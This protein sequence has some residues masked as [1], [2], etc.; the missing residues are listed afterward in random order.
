MSR[1][2]RG[3]RVLA[4]LIVLLL[5]AS[6]TSAA[7]VSLS[8]P[9]FDLARPQIGHLIVRT[10][11]VFALSAS[12]TTIVAHALSGLKLALGLYLLL[13]VL[14]AV[15]DRLRWGGS[16][17]AMLDVALCLSAF[18]AAVSAL[19][20]VAAGGTMLVAA[21]GEIILCAM[22]G[23][24]A[25]YGHGAALPIPRWRRYARPGARIAAAA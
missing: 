20:F 8:S 14:F 12:G 5:A 10:A 15:Y 18:A 11:G 13:A 9:L 7:M 16:D 22:A 6:W 2:R 17:D 3:A 24:L 19:V 1:S 23:V 4:H 25:A 21:L